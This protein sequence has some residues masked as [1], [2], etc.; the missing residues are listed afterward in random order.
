MVSKQ[1]IKEWALILLLEA[2]KKRGINPLDFQ[3]NQPD[4]FSLSTNDIFGILGNLEKEGLAAK[5][6]LLITN[7]IITNK[8][9]Q[10]IKKILKNLKTKDFKKYKKL[11]HYSPITE[12]KERVLVM[13]N[14]IVFSVLATFTFL[15][16]KYGGFKNPWIIFVLGIINIIFVIFAIEQ[17]SNIVNFAMERLATNFNFQEWYNKHKSTISKSII[18]ISILILCLIIYLLSGENWRTSIMAIVCAVLAVLI[19]NLIKM[20]RQRKK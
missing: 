5:A 14:F 19:I 8:G 9:E 11:I 6:P 13:E 4:D 20:Y 17:F 10:T 1:D 18:I 3:Y 7:F 12:I 16:L 15:I 2:S